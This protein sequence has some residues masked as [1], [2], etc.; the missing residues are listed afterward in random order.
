VQAIP[1]FQL[2]TGPTLVLV[3]KWEKD[4]RAQEEEKRPLL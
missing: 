3:W 2:K 1:E 4:G